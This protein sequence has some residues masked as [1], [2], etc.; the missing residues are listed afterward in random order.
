[1]VE[2][3]A[4]AGLSRCRRVL[5]HGWVRASLV[6]LVAF[7]A[8]APATAGEGRGGRMARPPMLR[9][10]P[11]G[12]R[13]MRQERAGPPPRQMREQPVP[14]AVP[15]ERPVEQAP[16]G[17]PGRLTPDERRALRQQINDAG[18]DIYRVPRR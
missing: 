9:A 5:A 15:I 2:R 7:A 18:R 3:S 12:P 14:Q 4:T 8:A 6:A 16:Q 13:M 17:H 10:A 11:F 1:M